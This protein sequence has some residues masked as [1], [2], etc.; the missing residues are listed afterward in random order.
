MPSNCDGIVTHENRE[1]RSCDKL[2]GK[3]K[4]FKDGH[5]LMR[6]VFK[7]NHAYTSASI[8]A[9]VSFPITKY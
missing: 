5:N 1:A 4:L 2:H 7:L 9:A 8:D 6:V 3:V